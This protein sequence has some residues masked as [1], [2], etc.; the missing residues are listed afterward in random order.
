MHYLELAPAPPLDALVHCIWFLTGTGTEPAQPVV[1]D[2]RVEL[3]IHRGEPFARADEEG[4]VRPQAAALVAGQLSSPIRLTP[5]GPVDVVGV[6]FRPAGARSIV[7][8]PLDELAGRVEAL[9]EIRP[10]LAGALQ[11]AASAARS[12]A[13]C[14]AAVSSV[15]RGF[16][17]KEPPKIVR[18]AVR[19]LGAVRSPGIEAIARNLGTSPRTLER[20]IPAEVGL[21]PKM[22]QRVLRFRRAFRMLDTTSPGLW[23]QAAAA[24][25]YYDQAHMIRE[26]RRFAGTAPTAFFHIDPGLAR[27]FVGEGE[28]A[29]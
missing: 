23:G 14:T 24:A 11:Q 1:P 12:P 29:A 8:L 20:R 15:L 6:R 21:S 3:I 4:R 22:L 26:F 27:A 28:P 10:A 18:A 16:V 9:S 5:R 17:E 13:A 25:G 2:G 19:A 7:G